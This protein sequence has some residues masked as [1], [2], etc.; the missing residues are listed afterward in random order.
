MNPLDLV[1]V[2]ANLIA[3]IAVHPVHTSI[4]GIPDAR[5]V[6]EGQLPAEELAQL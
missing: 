5:G 6:R 1:Y 2:P 3:K 4:T